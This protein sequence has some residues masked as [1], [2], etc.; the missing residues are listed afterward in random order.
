LRTLFIQF[1]LLDDFCGI[2]K[3]LFYSIVG[4]VAMLTLW[5]IRQGTPFP[6]AVLEAMV[7]SLLF[8][9]PGALYVF[10]ARWVERYK[11]LKHSDESNEEG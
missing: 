3:K 4:I 1:F 10:I 2:A 5:V 9:V 7:L 8:I 11:K 6:Q